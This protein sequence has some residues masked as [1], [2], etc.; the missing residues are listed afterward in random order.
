MEE[1]L[2]LRSNNERPSL[3]SFLGFS[4]PVVD[5]VSILNCLHVFSAPL[6]LAK[7]K[8]LLAS[9]SE[10][11]LNACREHKEK[12]DHNWRRKK[13]SE[14]TPWQRMETWTDSPKCE[15]ISSH[16]SFLPNCVAMLVAAASSSFSTPPVGSSLFWSMYH[17]PNCLFVQQYLL[18]LLVSHLASSSAVFFFLGFTF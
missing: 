3:P 1:K 18:L 6:P 16:A 13:N 11:T 5:E 14:N 4:F 17:F 10:Q 9:D 7:L 15:K 12:D 2:D 8:S